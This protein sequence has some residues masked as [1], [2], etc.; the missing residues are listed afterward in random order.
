MADNR[1]VP[2]PKQADWAW[3]PDRKT[4]GG[5]SGT[6]VVGPFAFTVTVSKQTRSGWDLRAKVKLATM[7][8]AGHSWEAEAMQCTPDGIVAEI[9]KRDVL[10]QLTE[11]AR[12]R[13]AEATRL[14]EKF[15]SSQP[16]DPA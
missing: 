3:A 11:T 5:Y 14:I 7:T 4:F 10:K 15:D 8:M 12:W 1:A 13:V 6:C 9:V 16:A 2:V